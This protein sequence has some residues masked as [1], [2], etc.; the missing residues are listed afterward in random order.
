MI[1]N[2]SQRKANIVLLVIQD[3]FHET[4]IYSY[5]Y[6]ANGREQGFKLTSS[7]VADT[8]VAVCECRNS[9]AIVVYYGDH[10]A[11]D[12]CSGVPTKYAARKSF[13]HN[14]Y[15]GAARWIQSALTQGFSLTDYGV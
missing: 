12:L 10:A 14:D 9:D 1:N 13:A 4:G 6:M 3:L 15:E 7:R 5:D 11:F 2:A 8:Y